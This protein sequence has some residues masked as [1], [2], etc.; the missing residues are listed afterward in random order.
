MNVFGMPAIIGLVAFVEVGGI[1]KSYSTGDIVDAHAAGGEQAVCLLQA[2]V[3]NYCC[4]IK[5]GI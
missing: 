3:P 4:P 1:R 5:I 2:R